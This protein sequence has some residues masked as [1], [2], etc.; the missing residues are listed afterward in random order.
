MKDTEDLLNKNSIP[1]KR[2]KKQ[3]NE[4]KIKNKY[5][6]NKSLSFSKDQKPIEQTTKS[7]ISDS[8]HQLPKQN[9]TQTK[10]ENMNNMAYIKE[11]DYLNS[12]T[13]INKD[14]K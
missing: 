9:K 2:I 10:S 4:S 8:I 12:D 6:Y 13:A 11:N 7:N 5:I 1:L 14:N 3:I